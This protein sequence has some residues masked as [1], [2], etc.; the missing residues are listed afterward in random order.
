[1]VT[2]VPW[3]RGV[4]P[5][6]ARGESAA[7]SGDASASR[8]LPASLALLPFSSVKG[9]VIRLVASAL[10][11]SAVLLVAERW[12]RAPAPAIPPPAVRGASA[13][14]K[15]LLREGTAA[16]VAGKWLEAEST[17][18][19]GLDVTASWYPERALMKT[20]LDQAVQEAAVQRD[21]DWVERTISGAPGIERSADYGNVWLD[22]AKNK[23]DSLWRY[24]G[25]QLKR[26]TALYERIRV[27]RAE[28][29]DIAAQKRADQAAWAEK[30]RLARNADLRRAERDPFLAR[31]LKR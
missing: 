11:G 23:L 3:Q 6:A 15:Q 14:S 5:E 19:H 27:V 12:P 4:A 10:F 20:G 28:V 2:S 24:Q 30:Q 8:F 26:F 25:A 21:L 13:Q 16:L 18:Q 1:M 17:F 31:A 29:A 9:T 22:D 7:L